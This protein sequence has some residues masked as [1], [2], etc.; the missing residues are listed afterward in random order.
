MAFEDIKL[1][2]TS[3]QFK[4]KIDNTNVD[5]LGFRKRKHQNGFD[6]HDL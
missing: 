1:D 3:D 2:G 4:N 5:V 6:E